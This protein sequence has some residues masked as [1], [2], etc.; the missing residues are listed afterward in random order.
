MVSMKRKSS[1]EIG[2]EKPSKKSKPAPSQTQNVSILKGEEPAFPRGGASVLTPL[3]HKQIQIQ[4]TRDVLFEQKTG[5]KS[6]PLD[7]EDEEN[8]DD[9]DGA[10]VK[11]SKPKGSIRKPKQKSRENGGSEARKES[12]VRIE[13][14]SYTVSR[15]LA[16]LGR[17]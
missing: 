11:V 16:I 17:C 2:K 8:E 12:G 1:P 6:G 5:K 4:A 10:P 9:Q 3:E 15:P 14:L 13:G 7:S